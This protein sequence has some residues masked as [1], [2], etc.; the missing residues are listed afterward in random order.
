MERKY[1]EFRKEVEL[2]L[3]KYCEENVEFYVGNIEGILES[4]DHL[5]KTIGFDT[6]E[7]VGVIL[8]RI[9]GR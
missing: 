8:D 7:D 4:L 1:S 5:N 6:N 3:K 9:M 2:E